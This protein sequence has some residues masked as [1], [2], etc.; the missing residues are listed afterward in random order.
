MEP[1]GILFYIAFF[2]EGAGEGSKRTQRE[3]TRD[4]TGK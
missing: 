2:S 1:I 3:I 4:L